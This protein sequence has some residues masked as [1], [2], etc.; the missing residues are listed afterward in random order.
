[1]LPFLMNIIWLINFLSIKEIDS[2][3]FVKK[4]EE[5]QYIKELKELYNDISNTALINLLCKFI[6]EYPINAVLNS[7][8]N[9][10]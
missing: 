1:M 10:I 7:F 8:N 6:I 5:K 2:S 4:Y 3:C 9:N